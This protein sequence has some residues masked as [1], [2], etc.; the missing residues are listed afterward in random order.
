MQRL[1]SLLFVILSIT[2]V[3]CEADS[4]SDSPDSTVDVS[5]E[6]SDSSGNGDGQDNAGL[7]T[8][9]EWN[10]LDHWSFWNDLLEQEEFNETQEYWGF[11]PKNRVDIQLNNQ[12]GDPLVDAVIRLKITGNTVWE[13]HTDN[14]GKAT[15]WAGLY[16]GPT[17]IQEED[18]SIEINEEP[19]SQVI[20]LFDQGINS[21][22]LNETAQVSN[23]VALSFIVDATG[24]MSDEISFL[25]ADLQNV[26][27]EVA[28]DNP[29]IDIYTSSVFYRDE[30]DLYLVRDSPMTTNLSTTID[31]IQEQNA[32]GGGDY[33]E[34]VQEGLGTAIHDLQWPEQAR[35]RIAFLLL[36]A[37]PH[38]DSQVIDYLQSTIATAAQ[39]G[40]KVIPVAASGIDKP[41]EFLLR[42]FAMSTNGT[43]VFITNDSGIGNDHIE[44]S[45]GEYQVEFLNEL[46][47]RLIKKYSA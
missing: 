3:G 14:Y 21:I 41:T 28:Q 15:L 27:E 42:Y 36:D 9:G 7:I 8:A 34:A 30:G 19:I 2:F 25:K 35:T 33:P 24:S 17:Q 38:Y 22:V 5:A 40:I 16:E 6:T 26:I 12:Q 11:Y 18:I 10:D 1:Y 32:G 39:N 45:V 20:T 46:L 13:A 31:F 37:P 23:T 47:I 4:R 43:Y 44:A 29:L